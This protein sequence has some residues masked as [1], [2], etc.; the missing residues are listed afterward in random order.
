MVAGSIAEP[1]T[2]RLTIEGWVLAQSGVSG[3]DVHLDDQHL[4]EAHLGLARQDVGAAFPKWTNS[5]RSGFAF[6]FPLRSLCNGSHI[7]TLVVRA[8]NGQELVHSFHIDVKQPEDNDEFASIRR[9]ATHLEA[10]VVDDVLRDLDHR[11]EFHLVLR[12]SGPLVLDQLRL[13][14]ESLRTQIY[15]AWHLSVLTDHTDITV[16]VHML[17]M[18]YVD[19]LTGQIAVIGPAES[20]L[21][22]ADDERPTL[23]GVLCPGDELGCDAL[24]EF[25][26]AGGLRRAADFLYADEF[27]HSPASD[28][29]EPF[30]KPDFSPDLLLSTN[31]VGRPWFAASDLLRRC[32]IT[33][34]ALL[35]DDEYHLVLRLTERADT[36]H[37]IPKLLARRGPD[38]LD[39]DLA[40]RSA[41]TR[42]AQRRGFTADVMNGCLPGTFRLKRT[43]P[44][45][46]KVSIIIPTCGVQGYIETC[47]RT[48]REK[49]AYSNYEIVCID[50]IPEIE[51]ERK[52]W[53][54]QNADVIVDVP[55]AFNWSEFNNQGV[56][57]T[58]GD[59]LMFLNDDIEIVQRDWLEAL[60]E[61]AQR[62]E[63]GVVG[64]LL[65][66]PNGSV[67]HAGVFLGA[68]NG[69]HAFRFSPADEPGYF[70]LALTQRNVIAVT[71]AC[72]LVRRS[73]FE[74]LGRFDE[75][76]SV[77]NNDLDFCLRA[78]QAG[79]L[80]VFTP[81]ATL[82]H[83]ELGSRA[84]LKDEFDTAHFEAR[85][86]TLFAA[87]DPYFSPR[88]SRHFD[89]YRPDDE[90]VLKVFPGRP[91]FRADEIHRILVVKLDHADD[92]LTALA[93]IRRLKK[94]FPQASI[95]VLATHSARAFA[96][97][98]PCVDKFI[99]FKFLH[100]RSQIGEKDLTR[101][102]FVSLDE[103]LASYRFDIAV[104]LCKHLPTRDVLRH[105]GARFLAGYDYMGQFPF[106]D[107]AIEW[108][109]ATKLQR[110][111]SHVV[112]DLLALAEAIGSASE[113]DHQL[114]PVAFEQLDPATLLAPLRALFDKPVVSI[115]PGA[116]STIKQWPMEYFVAL[117]DLLIERD[118]V[119]VLLIGDPDEQEL[120]ETLANNV[121]RGD[122]VASM[123]GQM[124]PA[125]LRRILAGCAL[126]IG[127]EGG[128]TYIAA[129][130]G[131]PTI[132]IH[133]GVEDAIERGPIGR[134]AV[135]LRRDMTCSPCYLSK[136]EDCPRG[137]ACLRCLEPS[138][139]HQTAQL[140]LAQQATPFVKEPLQ[141]VI[142]ASTTTAQTA[143]NKPRRARRPAAGAARPGPVSG[144]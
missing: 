18:D 133:S 60:L 5:L 99:E 91:L 87:G 123:T 20:L 2:G 74:A 73:L 66:Y 107:I 106:L 49:T 50:N 58:D 120:V 21:A 14:I 48:I 41:L 140:F 138:A 70:G 112:D 26:L 63:V 113:T 77:I 131:V 136:A 94:L 54:R 111:R 98:E 97:L 100:A 96:T 121:Q 34:R 88:L 33:P 130:Q 36:V 71:G 27:R 102:V 46:G 142:S 53:L 45:T 44:V 13:T 115:Y 28:R 15:R 8:R 125:E 144:A 40:T 110:K 80:T 17:L 3:I 12:Q 69:R 79:K 19:D 101:Q 6:R 103:E 129:A 22:A 55:D 52:S 127:N 24:A 89:D 9:R 51:I 29:R 135:A 128:P 23:Y 56:D 134:R 7:V 35:A 86:K 39:D 31:Y 42:A 90:P 38:S 85:W 76:H 122:R 81:H 32:G 83:H 47:I 105:T 82:I 1:M 104:D 10:N 30:F 25:A 59:Y 126:H 95:T 132:G 108:D 65:L 109:G 137:L 61:H 62:P 92:F 72:M 68:G 78:H 43:Q 37:H 93:A 64:A 57:A 141:A 116:D 16:A 118:G 114:L 117:I 4:G 67:Q 75:A 139:V 84:R 124:P 11:P 119:N 143:R